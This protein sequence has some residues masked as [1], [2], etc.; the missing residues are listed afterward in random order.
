[1]SPTHSLRKG[2]WRKMSADP[3]AITCYG[4]APRS[5]HSSQS[6][7][8]SSSNSSSSSTLSPSNSLSPQ[9][10]PEYWKNSP[11]SP[12]GNSITPV[13]SPQQTPPAIPQHKGYLYQQQHLQAQQ[14]QQQQQQYQ[15]GFQYPDSDLYSTV[16]TM[17]GKQFQSQYQKPSPPRRSDV[18]KLSNNNGCVRRSSSTTAADASFYPTSISPPGPPPGPIPAPPETFLKDLQRVM[19]K[20]WKVAQQL[21]IELMSTPHE[22]LGFRDPCYRAPIDGVSSPNPSP[23]QGVTASPMSPQPSSSNYENVPSYGNDYGYVNNEVS[24]H[25]SA[26]TAAAVASAAAGSNSRRLSHVSPE[27]IG[28]TFIISRKKAPPPPPKRSETTQLSRR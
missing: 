4:T 14:F 8:G 5:P 28:R 23:R 6:S 26:S 19:D 10:R 21:S 18:T 16:A 24:S 25:Y 22:I 15:Q 11:G 2:K 12:G 1:M 17:Q 13:G 27:D 3:A 20:K 7:S 9:R